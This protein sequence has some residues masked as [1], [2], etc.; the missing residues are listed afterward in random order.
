MA[1]I[2]APYK[3][4]PFNKQVVSPYWIEQISHDI[5]F[6]DGQSGTIEVALKAES[7][8]FVRDGIGQKQAKDNYQDDVQQKPH[9]FSQ[10]GGRYFIPGTSI[11]GMIRNV[12]EILSFGRMEDKV[13]DHRYAVR[14]FQNN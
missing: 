9:L 3:F 11:K 12:L 4:V 14:D 1:A 2:K 7:P 8:I 5:P 13:N 10:Y 6:S